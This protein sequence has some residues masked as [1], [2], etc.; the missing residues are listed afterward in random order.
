MVVHPE[1]LVQL[2]ESNPRTPRVLT[3]A[4]GKTEASVTGEDVEVRRS[5]Q[6]VACKKRCAV[7]LGK[8]QRFQEIMVHY[9]SEMLEAG[10]WWEGNRNADDPL[11]ADGVSYQAYYSEVGKAHYMGKDLTEVRS[12]Q[13]KLVPDKVGLEQYEQTSLRGIAIKAEVC[14][15]IY[16]NRCLTRKRV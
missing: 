8:P 10:S 14:G 4:E 13:R 11:H 6:A 12:P 9:T 1:V 16:I 7:E 15:S 3:L 2:R 5:Q